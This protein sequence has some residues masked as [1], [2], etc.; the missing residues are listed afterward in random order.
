MQSTPSEFF[1][2]PFDFFFGGGGGDSLNSECVNFDVDQ[3][4]NYIYTEIIKS[5]V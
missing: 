3:S 5:Y 4:P 1:D 2:S